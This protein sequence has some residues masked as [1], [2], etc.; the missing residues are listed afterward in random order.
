MIAML[1]AAQ[2]AAAPLPRA[3]APEA[4]PIP[5]N[6]IVMVRPRPLAK[7]CPGA[8]RMETSF[9]EPTALYRQ[10]DRPAKGLR[11]WADFPQG[12]F[13]KVEAAR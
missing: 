2:L 13:C 3:Q 11:K 12:S 10:G 1:L 8:G 7:D 9:L 4:A 6:E 5:G